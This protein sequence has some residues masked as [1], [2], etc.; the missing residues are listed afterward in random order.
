MTIKGRKYT[1]ASKSIDY[2]VLV[3]IDG[4]YLVFLVEYFIWDTNANTL[5]FN[6]KQLQLQT[7]SVSPNMPSTKIMRTG[8]ER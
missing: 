4:K 8:N 6:G 2:A 7:K 3:D 1:R 5:H